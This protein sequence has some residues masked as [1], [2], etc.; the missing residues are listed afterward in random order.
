MDSFF[1]KAIGLELK[2]KILGATIGKPFLNT[3]HHLVLP[4]SI[5]NEKQY[6]FCSCDPSIPICYL[7]SQDPS[8]KKKDPEQTELLFKKYISGATIES[9]EAVDMERILVLRL[10]N[11]TRY[12]FSTSEK[13]TFFLFLEMIG[14]HANIILTNEEKKILCALR[15]I[16]S[17]KNRYRQILLGE[18]YQ[19]PP[20]LKSNPLTL[21]E[22]TFNDLLE[23]YD[24]ATSI[25][26]ENYLMKKI[27]GFDLPLMKE[28]CCQ[29][30]KK[31][32]IKKLNQA[33]WDSLKEFLDIYQKGNF[34]PCIIFLSEGSMKLCSFPYE[35]IFPKSHSDLQF[36]SANE[37]AL[38]F[39]EIQVQ[40]NEIST[41][42]STLLQRITKRIEKTKNIIKTLEKDQQ[43]AQDADTYR[44]LG[45]L[46]MA[47]LYN[48]PK[49]SQ[50]FEV[51]NFYSP[52]KGACITIPLD[53]RFT[54]SQ[55][56]QKYYKKYTKFKNSMQFILPRLNSSK[57][58][59]NHLLPLEKNILSAKELSVLS[60]Y[61]KVLQERGILLKKSDKITSSHNEEKK[62]LFKNLRHYVSADGFE[63]LVGKNDR[64]ND[65]LTGKI[66]QKS[67]LWFHAQDVGGSHVLVRNPKRLEQIP[68][69]TIK[70]AA[71]LAAYF[72]KARKDTKVM[73]D[74]TFRKYISKPRGAKPGLVLISRKKSIL[75]CPVLNI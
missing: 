52:E 11:K 49:G 7:S 54:P 45:D 18:I 1:I 51:E 25:P 15:Y 42:R 5:K 62:E 32:D 39:H 9:V 70:Q 43:K 53:P 13:A 2:T 63:I 55:N 33:L 73:I 24:E 21:T 16:P 68:F 31:K 27:G 34:S 48:I 44:Q 6:F 46:I 59:L 65:T 47:N 4:L 3:P 36:S 28:L 41:L 69:S 29:A 58:E 19:Y 12:T 20:F 67:D 30:Q 72:S 60:D 26:L 74:Y 71:A 35:H 40:Q 64:G 50:D 10:T 75:V 17:Y 66:A 57:K 22:D 56:A 38:H 37:A 61:N 14:R 23:E 8:L